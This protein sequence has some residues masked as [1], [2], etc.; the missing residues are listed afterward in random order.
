MPLVSISDLDRPQPDYQQALD[1]IHELSDRYDQHVDNDKGDTHE[2]LPGIH[3]SEISGCERPMV[4]SLMGTERR[5]NVR[6][7]WKQRFKVGHALHRMLQADFTLMAANSNG[8]FTFEDEVTIAP[9]LQ[10]V[11]RYWTIQSHCDGLFTWYDRPGGSPT[12]RV[13]LEI[14]TA[15]TDV[16]DKLKGPDPSHIEQA[17]VYMA[18]LDAPMTWFLYFNKNNHNNT[19]SKGPFLTEFSHDKWSELEQRFEKAHGRATKKELP[20]RTESIKCE[21][22]AFSWTC[23]PDF[24]AGAPTAGPRRRLPSVRVAS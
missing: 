18:C 24:V 16:Y 4:Y 19:M 7:R 6:K 3:A 21:F 14:K 22:C 1:Q 12:L 15:S 23:Q 5:D 8:L 10:D 11:A 17:H 9:K 2:R 20:E 13:V